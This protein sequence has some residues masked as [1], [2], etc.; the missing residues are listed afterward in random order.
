MLKSYI[1]R[2]DFAS[3]SILLLFAWGCQAKS[4]PAEPAVPP[5]EVAASQELTTGLSQIIN[6]ARIKYWPLRYDFAEDLLERLDQI[7]ADLAGKKQGKVPR[8]LPK[9]DEEEERAHFRETARRWEAQTGKN[10]RSEINRLK[11]SVAARKPGERFHPE[12]Q[13]DFSASFDDFIKIEVLEIRERGNR[14]I[15]EAAEKLFAKYREGYPQLVQQFEAELKK[16]E[17]AL[18]GEAR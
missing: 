2:S 8:F 6:D 13:K 16:P 7:E 4:K 17:Y 18:P 10:F 15:H 11:A 3:L 14:V 9:L 5:E 1:Q 12:F